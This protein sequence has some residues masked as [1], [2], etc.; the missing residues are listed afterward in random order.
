M[1]ITS[2]RSNGCDDGADDDS[3]G[4][5]RVAGSDNYGYDNIAQLMVAL[6]VPGNGGDGD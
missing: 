1:G 3:N 4:L 2:G 5:G 6:L